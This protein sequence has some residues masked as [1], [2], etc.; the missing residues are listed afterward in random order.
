MTIQ[1]FYGIVG[2]DADE[3]LS[4]L[5]NEA[6]AKK[7]LMKFIDD[8]NYEML[9]NA[10]EGGDWETA[11][12]AAH[13]IKGLCLTL[14]LGNLAKSSSAL[15]ELLRGEFSGDKSVI[16]ADYEQVKSDYAIAIDALTQYKGN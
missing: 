8:P 10:V 3:V 13:T 5:M 12:R 1:Q 6:L 15:T 11:F 7:F 16:A 2:G 4:R 9:V 14:G